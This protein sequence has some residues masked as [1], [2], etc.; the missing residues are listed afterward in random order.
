MHLCQLCTVDCNALVNAGS[1]YVCR[2]ARTLKHQQ[3]KHTCLS[4]W[5]HCVLNCLVRVMMLLLQQ[6]CI[7]SCPQLFPCNLALPTKPALNKLLWQYLLFSLHRPFLSSSSCTHLKDKAHLCRDQPGT[8]LPCCIGL[9]W[10]RHGVHKRSAGCGPGCMCKFCRHKTA[11]HESC[12]CLHPA[13][14]PCHR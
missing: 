5:W 4:P 3:Q 14:R 10:H 2:H 1:K 6:R 11:S 12:S 13:C 8:P 7:E 9:S